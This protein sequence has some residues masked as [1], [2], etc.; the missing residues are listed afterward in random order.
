MEVQP[1]VAVD[2]AVVDVVADTVGDRDFEV[3]AAGI[4]D[5]EMM[6]EDHL[7]GKGKKFTCKITA[8]TVKIMR[9]SIDRTEINKNTM[10]LEPYF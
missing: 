8:R 5:E 9:G 4:Q 10:Y 3:V 7:Y 2:R 6:L 1:Y